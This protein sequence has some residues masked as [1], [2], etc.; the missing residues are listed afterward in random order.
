MKF[1]LGVLSVIIGL[2]GLWSALRNRHLR[3]KSGW[4]YVRADRQP[5]YF[6]VMT[7]VFALMLVTGCFL[8]YVAVTDLR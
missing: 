3:D 1:L 6:W 8:L 4:I 7:A 5:F 2:E